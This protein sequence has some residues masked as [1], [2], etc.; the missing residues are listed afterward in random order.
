MYIRFDIDIMFH[1]KH[2][3]I[4]QPAP[5]QQGDISC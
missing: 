4:L 1:A 2:F 3:V 5:G